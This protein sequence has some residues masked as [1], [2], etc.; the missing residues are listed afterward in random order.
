ME[1]HLVNEARFSAGPSIILKE[2]RKKGLKT[3]SLSALVK[4]SLSKSLVSY[5]LKQNEFS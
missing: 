2:T 3:L 4:R 1:K 5:G